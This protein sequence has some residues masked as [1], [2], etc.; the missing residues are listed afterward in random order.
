MIDHSEIII[1]RRRSYLCCS[2]KKVAMCA[3]KIV[4][5]LILCSSTYCKD[6]FPGYNYFT[7]QLSSRIPDTFLSV[8]LAFFLFILTEGYFGIILPSF[9]LR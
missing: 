4:I 2:N 9:L 6:G 8:F 5:V 3:R 7:V 1:I